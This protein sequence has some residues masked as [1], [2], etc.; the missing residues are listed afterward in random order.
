MW[1]FLLGLKTC[2]HKEMQ[3]TPAFNEHTD[4][5]ST[6]PSPLSKDTAPKLA[7]LNSQIS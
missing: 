1:V 3:Q 5:T 7:K 6:L 4:K 2:S